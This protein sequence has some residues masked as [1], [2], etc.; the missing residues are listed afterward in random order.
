VLNEG[1][2]V[3]TFVSG[4]MILTRRARR[5]S[6]RMGGFLGAP[7]AAMGTARLAQED[8]VREEAR[9]N[10]LELGELLGRSTIQPVGDAAVLLQRALDAYEAAERVFDRARDI[11]DLAGVLVLVRQG[12]DAFGAATAA[13]KGRQPPTTVPLCF[14]NPL[15]GISARQ[16]A[17]RPLGQWR[18]IKV[19]SCDECA[20][21]V[22][23]RGRPDALSCREHGHDVP[24]YDVDPN[25]SVWA[26]TGYGQFCDDLIER[27]LVGHPR[28]MDIDGN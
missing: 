1:R 16:V 4:V 28:H 15:H 10:I 6:G 9:R 18:A 11:A 7:A 12:R 14:F 20:K 27:V 26:A 8:E 17:W 5:K 25:H 13:A 22:K 23:R 3:L 2:V 19:R 21:R 24:Y